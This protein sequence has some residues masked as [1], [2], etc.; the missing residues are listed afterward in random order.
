MIK[1]LTNEEVEAFMQSFLDDIEKSKISPKQKDNTSDELDIEQLLNAF[2]N[3][4]EDNYEQ[5]E[6]SGEEIKDAVI[7]DIEEEV[8][9]LF[10][11]ASKSC[12]SVRGCP[13]ERYSDEEDDR[14]TE[15]IIRIRL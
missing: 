10:G 1:R 6:A 4:M 2:R 8:K 13:C 5:P 14:P 11:M 12:T 3:D 7:G 9:R 15:V